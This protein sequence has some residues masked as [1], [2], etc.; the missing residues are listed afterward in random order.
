MKSCDEILVNGQKTDGIY[1][2][3]PD[4]WIPLSVYCE[5]S[6]GGWTRVMNR[7][8][9]VVNFNKTW[10]EYRNGFGYFLT[11]YWLGLEH[12][13]RLILVKPSKMRIECTNTVNYFFEFDWITIGTE[14]QKY[15]F[16]F[17]FYSVKNISEIYLFTNH[18]GSYFTTYDKDNDQNPG[19]CAF[20]HNGGWWF[21]SCFS[22]CFTCKSANV[23]HFYYDSVGSTYCDYIKMSIKY[24]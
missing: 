18:N 17:G 22:F 5:L 2:I 4:N 1:K 9:N 10:I 15:Q 7:N 24:I 21:V 14:A 11:I 6:Q 3:Y 23:G 12:M 20:E 16:H 13:R 19:N 8:Q